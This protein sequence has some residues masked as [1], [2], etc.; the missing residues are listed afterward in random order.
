[1]K[2]FLVLLDGDSVFFEDKCQCAEEKEARRQR[3][4]KV[5]EEIYKIHLDTTGFLVGGFVDLDRLSQKHRDPWR[6]F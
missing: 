1:M 4:K 2:Y 6:F 3:K 5:Y